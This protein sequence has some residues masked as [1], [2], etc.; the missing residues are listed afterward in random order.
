MDLPGSSNSDPATSN[1]NKE[2]DLGAA[3]K[4]FESTQTTPTLQVNII[5][6]RRRRALRHAATDLLFVVSFSESDA[7]ELPVL[8][9]LIVVYESILALIRKLKNYFNDKKRRLCF[10]SASLNSM[11]S[12]VFSGGQNLHNQ[13]D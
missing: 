11:T 10:F 7:G 3:R 1:S 4:K 2:H 8:N 5:V 6:R 13:Q 9:C 12:T